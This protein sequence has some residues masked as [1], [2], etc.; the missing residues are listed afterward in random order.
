MIRQVIR[1]ELLVNLLSLRFAV[2]FVVCV[3][4]MGLIG[5]VLIEDYASRQ[6]TYLSDTQ[7]H[8]AAL[9]QVK[10]YSMVAV[11]LDVPPSPLSVFSRGM[12][13]LPSAIHVS[14][15]HVPTLLDE[16]Q[17]GITINLAGKSDRPF[18]P[19][20]R[21]FNA[22]DLVFV[23]STIL[24]LF[25]VLL[26]FDSFSGER[27]EGTLKLTLSAPVGR[28][29]LFTGKLIGALITLAIPV[30]I[31]FLEVMVMWSLSP[32]ISLGASAWLGV[33][34][35]YVCSLLFLTAFLALALFV[36]L[37]A[38]ESSSGLMYLLLLWVVVVILIPEG[39]NNI[40]ASFR[41]RED[42]TMLQREEDEASKEYLKAYAGIPYRNKSVWMNS[43]SSAFGGEAIL[44]ITTEEVQNRMEFNQKIFPLK[45]QYAERR[46]RALDSYA[47]GLQAWSRVRNDLVRPSLSVLYRNIVQ[48]I[49][50]TDIQYVNAAAEHARQFR[51]ALMAY[52]Q[53]KLG[54]PEWFTR[55]LEYPNVQPTPENQRRWQ[56][57]VETQG[58]RAVERLMS[59]D[60][61]TPIDLGGMPD[62][63]IDF[64]ALSERL[65]QALADILLLLG[66]TGV[67]L[68]LGITRA[69]R[70]PVR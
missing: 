39:G 2:G 65:G 31:G 61:V 51:T 16:G 38:T 40:A 56:E 49:A 25:A 41:P 1:K 63:R 7:L 46:Q 3:A 18:N 19:L 42:R 4:L 26:V 67:F 32:S 9:K 58:E 8:A 66:A 33:G 23:I 11:V 50:G 28:A 62:P 20:L 60:Q 68:I 12:N 34:L 55:A 17:G 10:V 14:P 43:Q 29:Q 5:Y 52:L 69:M 48:A 57:V 22:I 54:R 59:W 24:T 45:F 64:P 21:M 44:G 30:T 37:F 70:Y 47:A 6:Q 36:S 53:P 13:N 35:I 27:E 15:Y